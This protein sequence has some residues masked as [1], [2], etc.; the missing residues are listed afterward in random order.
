MVACG[1][2]LEVEMPHLH[3]RLGVY[4][5]SRPWTPVLTV[6]I[7]DVHVMEMCM[8]V[9][10]YNIIQ[11]FPPTMIWTL[12]KSEDSEKSVFEGQARVMTR[13]FLAK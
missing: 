10:Q 8:V 5:R 4:A 13:G 6:S 9:R 11:T 12:V 2:A 3:A 7:L 1:D